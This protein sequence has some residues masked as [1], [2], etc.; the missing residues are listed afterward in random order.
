MSVSSL[1][2]VSYLEAEPLK[3]TEFQAIYRVEWGYVWNWLRRLGV[4]EADLPDLT[5]EVFVRAFQG[6]EQCDHSR[7][8]RP[9]LF[10]IAYRVMLG[11][12]RQARHRLEVT[13]TDISAPDPGT[14]GEEAVTLGEHRKLFLAALEAMDLDRRAVF[15]LFEVEGYTAPE[16]AEVLGE[17]LATVYSRLERG[18][19]QFRTFVLRRGGGQ[20]E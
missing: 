18:R 11:F 17:R 10:G 7:P 20:H 4:Q 5:Q 1:Q 8:L 12:R 15:I 13:G 16:I 19:Q 2:L 14:T 6:W 3:L 9:W